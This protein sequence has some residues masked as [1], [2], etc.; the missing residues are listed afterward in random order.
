MVDGFSKD[1]LSINRGRI[2]LPSS[3]KSFQR[4]DAYFKSVTFVKWDDQ[5]PPIVRF[6]TDGSVAYVAVDK[7][8]I[9]ENTTENGSKVLDTTHFAWLSVYKKQDGQWLL[10]AIAS[11]NQ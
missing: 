6:S 5:T 3:D 9:V 1:F 2:D 7:L 11:T 4:F 8:V 10:D